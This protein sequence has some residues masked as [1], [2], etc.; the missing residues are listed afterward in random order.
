[1][2]FREN[3]LHKIEIN[4]LADKVC[5]SIASASYESGRKV[6]KDAMRKLLKFGNYTLRQERDLDLYLRHPDRDKG[7]ILVLD[8][9]LTIYDATIDD[10]VMRKSPLI[11]EMVSIRKVI[12]ILNDSDVVVSRKDESVR[13]IQAESLA[14]LDLSY[15]D[16]DIADITRDGI[17]SL[18][19]TYAEG[20]KESLALLAEILGYR[21]PS[22]AFS[23]RHYEIYG[24]L[25]KKD[26]GE[27][28][29][30]PAALYSLM[31][32]ELLLIDQAIGSFDKEKMAYYQK[33]GAGEQ[34]APFKGEDAFYYLKEA[35]INQKSA[36]Q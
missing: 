4:R 35:V 29:Y 21:P 20:V 27:I 32:N 5:H 13:R 15:T 1:M 7:L 10:V 36:V 22:K 25:V 2:S 14:G 3:L 24:A 9:D 34:P 26:S 16:A 18:H 6:D 19:S 17:A 28:V 23:V 12:K 30:G 33:V 31:N 8:N 11:K